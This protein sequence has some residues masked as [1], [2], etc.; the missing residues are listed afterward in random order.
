MTAPAEP[1]A[2]AWSRWSADRRALR[3]G[4]SACLLGQEVRFD[5]GHAR[6]RFVTDLLAEF[7]ELRSVCPE[8]DAGFGA[9]RPAMRLMDDG[10]GDVRLRVS[11]TG[12]DAMLVLQ[13]RLLEI[14]IEKREQQ[15]AR[16]RGEHVEPGWGIRSDRT[17][18]SRTGW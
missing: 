2:A 18:S 10:E 15:R 16:I 9:P 7:A 13:S 5:G 14:E 3:L 6:S 1:R 12:E 4:V 8:L 17:C 11:G